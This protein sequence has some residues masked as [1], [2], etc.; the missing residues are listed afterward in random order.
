MSNLF[1]NFFSKIKSYFQRIQKFTQQAQKEK[2][3][4]TN[5]QDYL[6][7]ISVLREYKQIKKL[8]DFQIL[9]IKHSILFYVRYCLLLNNVV[10][11]VR[12]NDGPLYL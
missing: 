9:F 1:L 11:K 4:M 8:Y 10:N 2:T 3:I 5:I 12:L 6:N 7:E